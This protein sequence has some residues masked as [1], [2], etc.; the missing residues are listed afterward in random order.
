VSGRDKIV[1]SH[2]VTSRR[3]PFE[4]WIIVACVLTGVIAL[5]P[6]GRRDGLIDHYLPSLA[7]LW[8]VGLLIAGCV[9]LVG[10]LWRTRTFTTVVRALGWE[11]AGLTLLVGLMI[12]YGGA[13]LIITPRAP[14]GLLMLGLAVAAG[15]RVHQINQEIKWVQGVVRT[16]QGGDEEDTAD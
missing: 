4:L 15:A 16:A 7:L 12:G 5:L 14:S 2:D 13:V 8:Y 1:T 3:N 9:T 10:A 6:I 11:R